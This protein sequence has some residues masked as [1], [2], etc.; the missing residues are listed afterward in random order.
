M[1]SSWCPQSTIAYEG[2]CNGTFC[3]RCDLA[4]AIFVSCQVPFLG[5]VSNCFQDEIKCLFTCWIPDFMPQFFIIILC[6]INLSEPGRSSFSSESLT[7]LVDSLHAE[8]VEAL[9]SHATLLAST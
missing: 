7:L 4:L 2:L 3:L 6:F 5:H 1:N 8:A 9:N